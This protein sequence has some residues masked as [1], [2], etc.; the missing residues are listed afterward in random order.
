MLLKNVHAP[1]M[2]PPGSQIY[3]EGSDRS[4]AQQELRAATSVKNDFLVGPACA[5]LQKCL[6]ALRTQPSGS[7]LSE[8]KPRLSVLREG[9]H[10]GKAWALASA[11]RWMSLPGG[12]ELFGGFGS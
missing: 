1:E 9:G 12:T 6:S 4:S 5:A 8:G 10:H 2:F 3:R 11:S 7:K